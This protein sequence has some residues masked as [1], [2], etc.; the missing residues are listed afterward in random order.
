[1]KTE[2][3]SGRSTDGASYFFPP[4]LLLVVFELAVNFFI[5][6]LSS[7]SPWSLLGSALATVARLRNNK[8]LQFE[9]PRTSPRPIC[10]CCCRSQRFNSTLH[11]VSLNSALITQLFSLPFF[12]NEG[13]DFLVGNK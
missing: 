9:L 10:C 3:C 2:R 11:I 12:S 1:M 5:F 7:S 4:A 6:R 8:D 13:E